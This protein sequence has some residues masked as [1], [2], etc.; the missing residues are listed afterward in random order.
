MAFVAAGVS[1]ARQAPQPD[2][3]KLGLGRRDA[4]PAA[5]HP[6]AQRAGVHRAP[7]GNRQGHRLAVDAHRQPRRV[8]G[9]RDF[10]GGQ[11]AQA[12]GAPAAKQAGRLA[13]AAHGN[14]HD[15]KHAAVQPGATTEAG[16]V[17]GPVRVV[18]HEKRLRR[19]DLRTVRA[20]GQPRTPVALQQVG[21]Q[22]K[23]CAQ[24]VV[25]VGR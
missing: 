1:R 20:G 25:T 7:D 15:A 11:H 21:Q 3:V 12:R 13:R 14:R 2:P 16:D 8:G 10:L 24:L 4:G 23:R 5:R 9:N 6:H 19:A 18:A 17:P 22:L